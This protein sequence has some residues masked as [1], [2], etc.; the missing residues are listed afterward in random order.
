M[1]ADS[2]SF[3][4]I[5]FKFVTLVDSADSCPDFGRL[6]AHSSAGIVDLVEQLASVEEAVPPV[7]VGNAD[8]AVLPSGLQAITAIPF[9]SSLVAD[10]ASGAA[11]RPYLA[12]YYHP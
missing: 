4:Q 11:S 2:C 3:E 8:L 1:A 7:M 9:G 6:A 12:A 10:L 5:G